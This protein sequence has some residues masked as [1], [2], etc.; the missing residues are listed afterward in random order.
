MA[1]KRIVLKVTVDYDGMVID[2]ER[3]RLALGEA[4]DDIMRGATKVVPGP[5]ALSYSVEGR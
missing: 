1:D 4:L 2:K 5:I 3:L